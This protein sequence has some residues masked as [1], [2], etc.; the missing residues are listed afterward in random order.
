MKNE[1]KILLLIGESAVG[2]DTILKEILKENSNKKLKKAVSVTTRDMRSG[3]INGID[4]YF[5]DDI[6]FKK[7][8]ENDSFIEETSYN[9]NG[10]IW[11]YG[12]LKDEFLSDTNYIIIAN[13]RG[14]KAFLNAYK[15]GKI[16]SKIVPIY[17]TCSEL[18]R[19]ERYMKRDEENKNILSQW[20]ARL[21]QD[22]LDFKNILEELSLADECHIFDTAKV[23][24]NEIAKEILGL[25]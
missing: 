18:I 5:V 13:P 10:K 24:T 4:Y 8:K 14:Y 25:L 19:K 17:L 7:Y 21:I 12:F 9:V 15:E 11:S 23:K 20:N 2:K 3:E 16:T 22:N 6:T 1:S